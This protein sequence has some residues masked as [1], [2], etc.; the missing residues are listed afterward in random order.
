MQKQK[1]ALTRR[2]FIATAGTA[3]AGAA[4][5]TPLSGS[6]LAIPQ[7]R[8]KMRLAIVGTGVRACGMYGKNLLAEYGDYVEIAGL[9][10]INPGRLAY[11][12]SY[13]GA[14]CPTFTDLDKMLAETKP[15]KLIVTTVDSTHHEQIIRGLE[16]GADVITEKPMTT[17]E[18]KAQAIL[19]AERRTGRN[20]IVTFNYRYSPH[21]ARIKELLMANAIG[22]VT[23]V[24]FHWYLDTEHGPRYF[25][26]WHGLR[27][28]S[29]T[30]LVHKSTHHFD[31]LNW[32]LDSDPEEVVAD[33]ALEIFGKNNSFR[34]T[35]CR[36]CPHQS[37]CDFY[38]DITK[39]PHD[40]KLYVENE[41]HDGYIR[42]ACVWREE[43]DIYDKMAVLIKYAN[44][45]QVTY[46]LTTY[47]PYEG[48]RI[49]FNGTK[50]RLEAWIHERQPWPMEEYD[51]LRLTMNFGKSELIRIPHGEGGH[52][53][54]DRR[55]LDKLF[56]D[57]NLPDPLKQSAGTRDG[58][59]SIL[60]GVAARKS[61]DSGKPVK[62][63]SLTDLK[64]QAKRPG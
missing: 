18:I 10:D 25:R 33:G 34:S 9:C 31:L 58:A 43:I 57:P 55:L 37:K 13:M 50:G 15:D 39:S 3:V 26:R 42:D 38:W 16:T 22:N 30:L 45:V 27:E 6:L 12:K 21:R 2:E 61:I 44:G 1:S 24:D 56:K 32:W 14:T 19:D 20:A 49:A 17:D 8:K 28:K 52:G 35:K 4:I 46:S 51:E 64:P 53:G 36:G 59:M 47:S 41:H 11:A 62:I 7:S 23:S 29:G 48:Y 63:A 40:T 5:A 60:A 54:G